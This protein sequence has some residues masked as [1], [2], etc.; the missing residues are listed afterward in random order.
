V[1]IENGKT[2]VIG[3]LM[4]DRKTETVRKVPWLGDVPYI[5]AAF[6]RTERTKTK[7]ELLIF[8]TPH[9]A[10]SPDKLPG[11]SEDETRGT[12]LL[13][14][15]VEPGAYE[16]HREG[17]QRGATQ[18]APRG[19]ARSAPAGDASP[20]DRPVSPR[21]TTAPVEERQGTRVTDE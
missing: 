21:P 10:S 14:R 20:N 7:T 13:D 5:G 19:G 9:V 18:V 12:K 2:I 4:E 11:M 16:S 15:A 17:L 6:R 1:S 3:G 8:L